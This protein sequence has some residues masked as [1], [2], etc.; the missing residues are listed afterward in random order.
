MRSSSFVVAGI[1]VAS[2]L[3]TPALAKYGGI[4]GRSG[5][6]AAEGTAGR[7]CSST[8]HTPGATVPIVAISG[9][10]SVVAGTTNQYTFIIKGGPAVNGGVNLAVDRVDAALD[11]VEN[12]GLRKDGVEL[13][14]A[15]PKAFSNG[16]VRFDFS[17]IAPG[18][19]GLVTIYGAGN[20]VNGSGSTSGDGVA[21]TKLDVT[22]QVTDAGIEE[23]DS[24]TP[25]ADAGIEVDAG[26]EA[27][28]GTVADAGTGT[29]SDPGHDHDH[30]HDDD[31]GG[32]CS[33]T[34]GAPMLMF[35]LGA[36]GLTLLRRRRA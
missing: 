32:G 25:P 18:N 19:G 7:T 30:D 2:V 35:V 20:S 34:G 3:S 21:A 29:G 23:P 28:A 16:E 27:D 24:G 22:V 13:V 5:K 8:C 4:T 26:T 33:S 11:L 31:K 10:T 12:S 36:V 1:L 14:H 17:M 15:A 9:P 6:P